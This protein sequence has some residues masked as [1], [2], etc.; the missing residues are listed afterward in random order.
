MKFGIYSNR[1]K[2]QGLLET[3]KLISAVISA[4]CEVFVHSDIANEFP[5]LANMDVSNLSRCVDIMITMGGDGTILRVAPACAVSGTPILGVNLGT[6]GFLAESEPNEYDALIQ[7]LVDGSYSVE[8]RAMLKSTT[9]KNT[10][11][12]LNEIMVGRAR[13]LKMVPTDVYIDDNF[14]YRYYADGVMVATPTGSTGYSLSAGG[15]VL[16]PT[17][18]GFVI[19]GVCPHSLQ[20]KPVVIGHEQTVT[21]KTNEP[22][23]AV[24]AS[25]GNFVEELMPGASVKVEKA[26]YEVGFIRF[27]HPNFY[28]RLINKLNHWSNFSGGKNNDQST[29]SF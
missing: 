15:P 20:D 6:L 28:E 3:K 26:E 10:Y 22:H 9:D 7:K 24:L 21:L 27:E 18:K 2:D 11:Y 14:Y 16:S 4:G 17:L 25:D 1:N 29:T 23:R 13:T 5:D 19:N 8:K 12:S